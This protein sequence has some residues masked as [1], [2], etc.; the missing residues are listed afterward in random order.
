MT[1]PTHLIIYF[2]IVNF[3]GVP[4]NI[5]NV[6]LGILGTLLP[7]I[8]NPHSRIGYIFSSFSSYIYRKY[9]H[10]T[11]THSWILLALF[12]PFCLLAYFL[13]DDAS[14]IIFISALAI[15]IVAD[16]L[17]VTG[18]KFLY[19]EKLIFVMPNDENFRIKT[20]SK[21]EKRFALVMCLFLAFSIPF[22]LY[23]YDTVIRIIAGSTTATIEEYKSSID[24]NEVFVIIKNGLNRVTQEPIHNK[25][26]K[27]VAIMPKKILLVEDENGNRI[28]IGQVEDAIIDSKKIQL[29]KGVPVQT[30]HQLIEANQGWEKIIEEL[31]YPYAYAIGEITLSE[32]PQY[33]NTPGIWDGIKINENIVILNYADLKSIQKLA[34]YNIT[35]GIITIKK[36]Y[37]EEGITSPLNEIERDNQKNYTFLVN[38]A[39]E[40]IIVS[41]GQSVKEGDPIAVNPNASTIREEI[42]ALRQKIITAEAEES[43]AS[44][45]TDRSLD[46]QRRIESLNRNIEV[47][48]RIAEKAGEGMFKEA[49]KSRLTALEAEKTALTKEAEEVKRSLKEE[50]EYINKRKE[51]LK[52]EI[53][54]QIKAQEAK[55]SSGAKLSPHT[56]KIMDIKQKTAN[57]FE[58]KIKPVDNR[59]NLKT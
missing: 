8:S 37:S 57:V 13:L 26:F 4:I 21:R 31:Q 18:V 10:R 46:I 32:K 58:I 15:H 36:E 43:K 7:D 24:K 35:D 2:T 53:N 12:M 42:S 49:E 29:K 52:R 45:L 9:D 40:N 20:G 28:T 27:V 44:A 54:A 41:A 55:I 23:G 39:R 59:D 22:G 14:P 16:M 48:K 51:S 6:I 38:S 34:K 47:Q 5:Q 1:L 56:G 3:L 33:I 19:P 17:N 25:I 30:S 50:K 11:I